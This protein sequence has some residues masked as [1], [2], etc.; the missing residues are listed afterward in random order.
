MDGKVYFKIKRY[1]LY[2][3]KII[4]EFVYYLFLGFVVSVV[5]L[6]FFFF[7]N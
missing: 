6:F 4:K 3:L 1:L 5:R 7:M 2:G